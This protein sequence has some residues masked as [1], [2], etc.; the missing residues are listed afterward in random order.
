MAEQIRTKHDHV[1][2]LPKMVRIT[3]IQPRKEPHGYNGTAG[4]KAF[5]VY[6]CECRAYK[7]FDY[8][9]FN[10]MRAKLEKIVDRKTVPEVSQAKEAISKGKA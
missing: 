7:A 2:N 4:D 10:K 5:L 6:A 3:R 1:Y 9:S 8:G